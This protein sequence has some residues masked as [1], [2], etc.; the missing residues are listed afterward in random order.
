MAERTWYIANEGRQE[1]PFAE[2]QFREFI[3]TGRVS[4]ETLVW[5]SGMSAWQKAGDIPGLMGMGRAPPPVPL[6]GGPAWPEPALAGS[7]AVQADFG[8]WPLLGRILLAGLGLILVIPA[9]WAMTSYYRWFI[10]HLRVPTVPNIG[11]SG[12]GGDIWWA[13]V[14]IALLEYAGMARKPALSLLV[15]VVLPI[16]SWVILRWTLANITSEG[17]PLGL[18]FTGS[19]WAYLGWRLLLV[20]SFVTIIGWAWVMTAFMRWIC[21]NI[22][23]ATRTASFHATGWQILWRTWVFIL[24]VIF[25]IPIPWTLRWYVRWYVS[26][27][28]VAAKTA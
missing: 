16:L 7:Q 1:G 12:K 9:P 11:F 21:R 26:K 22:A 24:T 6:P 28:S 13:F 3:A 27:F 10:S 23:D 15:L 20:L 2:A 4:A 17:R 25:I 18:S 5:T 14:L 8:V 19:V